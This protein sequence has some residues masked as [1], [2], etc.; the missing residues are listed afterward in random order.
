MRTFQFII[1]S[2]YCVGCQSAPDFLSPSDWTMSGPGGPAVS[3]GAEALFEPCATLSGGD[4]DH[5]EHN[6]VSM[7]DGYLLMPWA[8]ED[9]SGGLSFFDVSDPCAP[10]EV[11][12]V[13]ASGWDRNA[14]V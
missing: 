2:L 3:F 4:D 11:G 6:L 5:Q 10:K 14:L 1:A 7:V 8:P 12:R 13:T 9:A